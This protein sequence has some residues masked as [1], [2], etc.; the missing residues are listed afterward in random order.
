M[1]STGAQ[2][3]RDLSDVQKENAQILL[4]VGKNLNAPQVA[5]EAIICAG[6]GESSLGADPSTYQPNS[7]GYWGVLQGGSGQNGSARNFPDAHNTVGMARHFFQGGLGFQAG[8]AIALAH[9]GETDPGTIAT[10]VEASGEPGSYYGQYQQLA[11]GLIVL[12]H[13]GFL[14]SKSIITQVEGI[15]KAGAGDILSVGGDVLGA[16]GSVAESIAGDIINDVWGLIGPE[17]E[18]AALYVV[19]A[20]AGV[21][22]IAEGVGR[23][24]GVGNPVSAAA[25]AG[26][27]VVKGAAVGAA[28]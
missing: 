4:Q 9:G 12:F 25:R 10:K 16:A 24:T 21:W 3:Y 6:M 19:L 27:R 18:K 23:L 15:A 2:Q 20:I 22:L 28:A 13:D 14:T 8:G 7:A 5:M 1:A 26:G 11:Q 17:V